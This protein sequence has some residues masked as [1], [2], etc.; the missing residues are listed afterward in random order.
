MRTIEFISELGRLR[1]SVIF[2]LDEVNSDRFLDEVNSDRWMHAWRC[3]FPTLSLIHL[4]FLVTFFIHALI[5]SSLLILL[6][7]IRVLICHST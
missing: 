6:L 5:S 7:G 1:Y 4:S 3:V 2:S